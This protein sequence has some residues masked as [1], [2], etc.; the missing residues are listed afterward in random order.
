[1]KREEIIK[2]NKADGNT[3]TKP[4]LSIPDRIKDGAQT[5][6]PRILFCSTEPLRLRLLQPPPLPWWSLENNPSFSTQRNH[7][8][9]SN[10]R[11]PRLILSPRHRRRQRRENSNSQEKKM[12]KSNRLRQTKREWVRRRGRREGRIGGRG[13]GGEGA[14]PA[15]G[16]R[17]KKSIEWLNWNNLG[18]LALA[19]FPPSLT[20]N[21]SRP[22]LVSGSSLSGGRPLVPPPPQTRP[23]TSLTWTSYLTAFTELDV[24]SIFKIK[25]VLKLLFFSSSAVGCARLVQNSYSL[26]QCGHMAPPPLNPGSANPE[27]SLCVH[28]KC[29]HHCVVSC[30]SPWSKLHGLLDDYL[31]TTKL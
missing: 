31:V 19:A 21:Q 20:A 4:F 2:K 22:P 7:P 25:V 29:C 24:A 26:W 16:N 15:S 1:M 11:V 5:K 12:A 13:W 3:E 10:R 28:A 18:D 9:Q 8:S 6:S 30:L 23:Q 27:V 14:G 17:I